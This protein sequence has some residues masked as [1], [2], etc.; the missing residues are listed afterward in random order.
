MDSSGSAILGDQVEANMRNW[1]ER[2]EDHL[3]AYDAAAF[4][5]NPDAVWAGVE[6]QLLAPFVPN[7]SFVGVDMVHLQC[8]IG[9]DTLSFARRGASIVGTDLSGEAIHAAAGLAERAGLPNATFVQCANEDAS[10]L[11]GRTFDVVFTSVGVL[12]WLSDLDSWAQSIQRLLRPGG[13]FLV[14]DGHPM[15]NV[16]EYERD[17]GKLVV[18][19]PYFHSASPLRFDDGVTYASETRMTNSVTYQ[20]PHD[21]AEIFGALLGVGLQV[22]AFDEHQ[23]MPWKALPNLEPT[24]AGWA[25]PVTSPKIPLM[26]SIVARRP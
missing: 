23:A 12:T 22:E 2:V 1:D 21:L 16:M 7:G 15:M 8:H 4:V 13:V 17:D 18:G 24:D 9:L 5:D 3:V 20:W 19:E 11:L 26:F 10:D 6:A 14:Y 25:L